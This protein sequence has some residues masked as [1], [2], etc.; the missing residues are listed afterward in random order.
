[1][2]GRLATG[3]SGLGWLAVIGRSRVPSPPA[4]TTAF[5]ADALLSVCRLCTRRLCTR[6]GGIATY[7]SPHLDEVKQCG[8]PVQ[9]GAPYRESPADHPGQRPAPTGM[10]SEEQQ[11]EGVQ[12]AQRGR[13]ADEADLQPADARPAPQQLQGEADHK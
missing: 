13:L 10:I 6:W 9:S 11:R 7:Q 12:Q 3:S 4:M 2:I 8:L 1:M 5:K